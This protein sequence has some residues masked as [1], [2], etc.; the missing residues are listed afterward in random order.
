VTADLV[1]DDGTKVKASASKASSRT[2]EELDGSIGELQKALEA[3]VRAWWR[4]AD[5]RLALLLH[6]NSV[7][8]G[9]LHPLL[10]A[11]RAKPGRHR[12]DQADRHGAVRRR[13]RVRGQ[14]HRRMRGPRRPGFPSNRGD[15]GCG[16]HV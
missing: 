12:R 5:L 10:K 15:F 13:L 2:L 11:G 16:D 8:I 3:E 7:D 14:L 6:D 1:A 9:A 4:Q